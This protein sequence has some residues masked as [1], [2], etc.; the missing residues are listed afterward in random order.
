ML[1][2]LKVQS[3]DFQIAN[4]K[5][6][7]TI[8]TDISFLDES[9]GTMTVMQC[10]TGHLHRAKQQKHGTGCSGFHVGISLCIHS[11][12]P[13]TCYNLLIDTPYAMPPNKPS[14][15]WLAQRQMRG[16]FKF[17]N[18]VTVSA[19]YILLTAQQLFHTSHRICV[20]ATRSLHHL[21]YYLRR[22]LSTNIGQSGAHNELHFFVRCIR[23]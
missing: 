10:M 16:D 8:L 7:I 2:F 14:F 15:C 12:I 6:Y 19:Q 23:K 20:G 4:H 17:R 21:C 18:L 9:L 5:H 3:Y 11:I 13:C 1:T 22:I